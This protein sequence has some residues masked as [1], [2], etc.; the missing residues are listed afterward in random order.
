M[1]KNIFFDLDDT[2]LDFKM[3]ERVALSKALTEAGIAPTPENTA[4]YSRINS[5]QWELLEAGQLDR[6][7]LKV[8]R[9]RLFFEAMG[10]AADP[11]PTALRYEAL[12]GIGH[13]WMPGAR[14]L[15]EDLQG[16]Y[17]LYLASNG[18]ADVQ[19]GRLA[20]AG[21]EHYFEGIFI[22]EEIGA[23]KP[24]PAYFEKCFAAIPGFR[25]EESVLVGDR[26]TSDILGGNRVGL[27]TVWLNPDNLPLTGEVQPTVTIRALSRLPEVLAAL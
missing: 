8:Q 12:L 14:Q 11:V 9:F 16:R 21:M 10:V 5:R 17:R 22:S 4:L 3:A 13:Y 26:L 19:H 2:L 1:V 25:R 6:E 15:L 27:R 7:T 24:S 20:S 23:D 18:T